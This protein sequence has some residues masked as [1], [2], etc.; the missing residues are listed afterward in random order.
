M[1][2]SAE[3]I[4]RMRER[5][6]QARKEREEQA[7]K[8]EQELK[9]VPMHSSQAE[10]DTEGKP[11]AD[12]DDPFGGIVFNE[13]QQQAI[14]LAKEGK[15]FC[16][17]GAA[18]TG[19]T[20]TVK[21]I[22][23]HLMRRLSD[24]LSCDIDRLPY[25]AMVMC[26]FTNRAVN[27]LRLSVQDVDAGR[28]CSTIHSFLRFAPTDVILQ[29]EEGN[30]YT[31][32]RFLPTFDK[33]NPH[34]NTWLVIVEEAS[35]VSVD[36]FKQLKDATPNSSYIFLGDL[37]Q[38]PPVFGDAILGYKLNE[39]PVI[40]LTKVYRQAM[41]SPIIAFQHQFTLKG[42]LPG[43][44]HLEKITAESNGA[45]TFKT[46]RNEN[47][48]EPELLAKGIAHHFISEYENGRYNW[49]ED[50]IL[51]P[52]NKGFGT[53]EINRTIAQYF[54]KKANQP[55]YEIIAGIERKYFAVGDFVI[56]NK[57]EYVISEI[58]K[59]SGF[60]SNTQPQ[61][62]SVSLERDGH[63]PDDAS[64][65]HLDAFM[66]DDNFK[67]VDL[68]L[69]L[70]STDGNIQDDAE[71]LKAQASHKVSLVPANNRAAEPTTIQTRGDINKLDFG[72][73]ITIH[74]AQG[75]EWERV[76]LVMTN[77]HAPMLSRE[78]LYTGMTRAKKH[79]HV[80]YS[81]ATGAGRKNSSIARAIKRQRITG[82]TWQEKAR[83]FFDKQDQYKATMNDEYEEAANN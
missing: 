73:A 69:L 18:G 29:D 14:D 33:D 50:I 71:E 20:T 49:E 4:R 13:Q 10:E 34:R 26:S 11:D 51:I 72:Y 31:S 5:A 75:S 9:H 81:P 3:L 6:A 7:A 65:E 64:A 58:V 19:K 45:L 44:T 46:I 79:L 35:M 47:K 48:Y 8:R 52:Y 28:F 38:L 53:V 74:K 16:L 82:N 21:A 1:S 39:L 40:E 36:L 42:V 83:Q 12:P 67:N 23:Y 78:L 37:N 59:N 22:S 43:E 55:V 57:E 61:M 60:V 66:N 68:N 30:D 32:M 77:K 17:I 27:N 41:D 2:S 15:E 56:H 24:Q 62:E 80:L 25:D 76:Y 54:S 70:N 63:N